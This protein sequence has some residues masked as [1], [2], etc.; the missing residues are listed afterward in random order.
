MRASCSLPTASF[1]SSAW[2]QQELDRITLSD[3][4]GLDGFTCQEH[5]GAGAFCAMVP[6]THLM[7]AAVSQRT[8]RLKVAVTGTCIPLHH[9]LAVAE[10]VAMLDHLSGGRF[11]W[12]ALRGFATEYLS[13]NVNPAESQG[14]FREGFA[15]IL[16]ALSTEGPFDFD[17]QYYR[18][19]NYNIWPKPLQKP[20]PKIWMAANSLDSLDFAVKNRT[21]VATPF[22]GLERT[23]STYKAYHQLAQEQG[24]AVPEDFDNMFAAV[25]IIYVSESDKKARQEAEAHIQ[26]HFF[27]GLGSLDVA[28][29]SLVPGHMSVRG[30]RGWLET[31]TSRDTGRAMGYS[32]DEGIENG[33]VIC[34]SPESVVAQIKRQREEGKRGTLLAMFQFGSLPGELATQSLRLFASE[35]L[36]KIR[37]V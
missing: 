37:A 36:P 11:I 3:E 16:K 14:R 12:G 32:V 6:S 25:C 31:V 20:Y 23:R 17:G 26:E 19:R 5:H 7:A 18:V 27:R 2:L 9:P 35:V 10:E 29:T 24:T 34:G 4:L 33:T 8:K 30:V 28:T 21:Y 22:V 13:Y 1:V 15:L